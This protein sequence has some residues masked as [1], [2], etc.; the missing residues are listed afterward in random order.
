MLE[1]ILLGILLPAL[2]LKSTPKDRKRTNSSNFNPVKGY[3]YQ[4]FEDELLDEILR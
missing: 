4:Y 3:P 2:I 1:S